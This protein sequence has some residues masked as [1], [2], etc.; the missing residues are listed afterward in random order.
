MY[1]HDIVTIAEEHKVPS[2]LILN[3][4]QTPLKYIPVGR[5]SLPKKGSKSV[6]IAGSADKRNI[7]GTF[8]ITLSGKFLP[9]QLIY[10]GK[11]KESLP[12]FKFPESF[13]LSA[14]PKHFSNKAESLKV[15]EEIIFPYVKQQC[16]ELEKLDQAV[17]LIMDVFRGQMTEEVVSM[18]RTNNI[19]LVKVP[20]N[21]TH[22]LQPYDSTVNG[23]CKSFM[24]GMFAEWYRKQ[25]E[26][27]L[28]HG[29]KVE[30]IEIKFY[31]TVIKPLH[32]KW[33]MEF[34]NHITSEK[35]SEIII[36]GWKSSV[37]NG[38]SSSS[39][40]DLVEQWPSG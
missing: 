9:K 27:A 1:L 2:C 25:V 38:S 22:L 18:L 11:T 19:W 30:D 20:N 4:D 37:K 35:G 23:H 13:S 29:K 6:L 34:C 15:I 33:L 36:N 5:Q 8:I 10:G 39:S 26:E 31:L 40:I 3:L 21:M 32:A 16:Q 12:R 17:I 7:T 28:S 24:K 14:N